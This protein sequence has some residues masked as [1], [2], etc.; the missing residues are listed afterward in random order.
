MKK[1]VAFILII[2]VATLFAG[3]T[4]AQNDEATKSADK[5]SEAAERAKDRLEKLKER[6]AT[7]SAEAREKIRDK[8]RKRAHVSGE[9][10]AISGSTI[11]IQTRKDEIKTI[12]TD[13]STKFLQIGKDGKKE[14]KLSDLKVGDRIAS[15][16]IAPDENSG[17]AKFVVKL[18]K[19]TASRHAVFGEVSEVGD[20]QLTVTH[21]IHEDKPATTVKTTN[22]TVIK[23][24][25]NEDAKFS[26]IEVGDKVAASGTVDDK[27]VISAKR[28]F[29][30]P[31]KF[32]GVKPKDATS[33]A[34]PSA[35]P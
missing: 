3:V 19:P 26:E 33:S 27:G 32:D 35:T 21:L 14:I 13:D 5:K 4:F 31:G 6:R 2:F 7:K 11:T 8:F 25:G 22:D 20:G 16:G 15:V 1:L 12:L 10:T 17:I 23:I 30:I 34:T 29:V 18:V 9:I 28:L 24:R